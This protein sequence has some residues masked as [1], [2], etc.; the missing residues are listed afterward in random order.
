MCPVLGSARGKPETIAHRLAGRRI[1]IQ[2]RVLKRPGTPLLGKLPED[3]ACVLLIFVSPDPQEQP[4]CFLSYT[5]AC[6]FLLALDA[7]SVP[8]SFLVVRNRG[9]GAQPGSFKNECLPIA[10][11]PFPSMLQ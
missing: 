5:G 2:K 7:Y 11:A 3:G 1:S 9:V 8:L 6:S 4:F 10:F